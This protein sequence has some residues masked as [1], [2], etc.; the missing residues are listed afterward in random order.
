[1]V[2]FYECI[3]GVGWVW[4]YS[5][6][7]VLRSWWCCWGGDVDRELMRVITEFLNSVGLDCSY[8]SINNVV[9]VWYS[10]GPESKMSNV[11]NIVIV[12]DE[13]QVWFG[14]G[15]ARPFDVADPNFLES[16]VGFLRGL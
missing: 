7:I 10:D 15:S 5:I 2:V 13:V 14:L 16:L 1:M 3:M 4:I 11:A 12:N 9:S 8:N 6:G